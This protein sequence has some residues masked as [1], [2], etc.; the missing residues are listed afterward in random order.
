MASYLDSVNFGF[1]ACPDLVPDLDV[2]ADGIHDALSELEKV[3]PV[4]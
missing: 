3:A 2:L 1:Q 4:S